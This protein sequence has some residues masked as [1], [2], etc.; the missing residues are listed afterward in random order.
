MKLAKT[1][2]ATFC[3]LLSLALC[4]TSVLAADFNE[5]QNLAEQGDARAQ[6]NLAKMYDKGEGVQQDKQKAAEWY[7]KAAEQ[8]LAIA[9][10]N[11]GVLYE[12]GD[13]VEQNKAIAEEW[14]SKACA[15][16]S[17]KACKAVKRLSEKSGTDFETIF[18]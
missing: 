9:Q 13:G 7:Q 8:G 3:F 4:A 2:L 11:L 5:I 10:F 14:Y 12:N 17:E 6:F 16:G 1:V 15:K 18:C